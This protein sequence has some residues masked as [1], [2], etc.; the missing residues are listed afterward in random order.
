MQLVIVRLIPPVVAVDARQRT[1][2]LRVAAR[3]LQTDPG[4]QEKPLR[5]LFRCLVGRMAQFPFFQFSS[6][7]FLRKPVVFIQDSGDFR[8]SFSVLTRK[9]CQHILC[10][11]AAFIVINFFSLFCLQIQ[12]DPDCLRLP[13]GNRKILSGDRRELLR[14]LKRNVQRHIFCPVSADHRRLLF[15][16]LLSLT[17][18]R[19]RLCS[20]SGTGTSDQS[21]CH[22]TGKCHHTQASA[23][24]SS[25]P[26]SDPSGSFSGSASSAPAAGSS[27]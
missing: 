24:H 3:R 17:G 10:G 15:R 21:K 26:F 1:E 22:D 4:G 8:I 18:F 16:H 6:D 12:E 19:L 5:L 13:G 27:S 7:T 23:D 20:R 14:P 2:N 25:S 11:D 9:R